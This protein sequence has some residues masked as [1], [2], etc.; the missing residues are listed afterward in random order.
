MRTD[1]E[2]RQTN[3]FIVLYEVYKESKADTNI[4]V[5]TTDLAAAKGV[6]NGIFKEALVYLIDEGFLTSVI[7]SQGKITH[8]GVKIVEYI[9]T[10][11]DESTDLF[12]SFKDMGI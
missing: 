11:P 12:P 9:I 7:N 1:I 3:R 4:S 5:R 2:Q 10:H 6:K 8:G